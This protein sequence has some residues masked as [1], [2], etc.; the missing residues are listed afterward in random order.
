MILCM[1][2]A[3]SWFSKSRIAIEYSYRVRKAAPDTWVFWVTFDTPATVAQDF[4]KIAK[5]V[6][7]RGWDEK[8]ADIFTMVHDWLK[9]DSN[10]PWTL[11][12]DNVD[13]A[14]PKSHIQ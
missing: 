6:G 2:P 13:C 1:T 7:L 5:A 10:G 3:D 4:R 9:D 11:I 8:A 14:C 12:L